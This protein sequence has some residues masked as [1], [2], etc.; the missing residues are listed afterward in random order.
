MHKKFVILTLLLSLTALFIFCACKDNGDVSN[1]ADSQSTDKQAEPAELSDM[2]AAELENGAIYKIKI[3]NEDTFENGVFTVENFATEDNSIV[4]LSFY[5]K[6]LSQMW[7]AHKNDDGTY[8]LQN[9]ASNMY[10][11]IRNPEK[12]S[13]EKKLSV[14]LDGTDDQA[15]SWKIYSIDGT[16]DKC[17]MENVFSAYIAGAIETKA[18]GTD[19]VQQEKYMG[20]DSQLWSFEKIHDGNIELPYVLCLKGDWQGSSSCPEILYHDGIYYNYNMTGPITLKTSTDLITWT[21]HEDKY[22]LP[23]R[24]S[25]MT[26]VSGGDRIWAP[27]AY[28]IGD[29]YFLYYCTSSAGSQNSGIGVAVSEDPSKN[30][31]QD[32]GLVIRSYKGGQYNCIDPNIF[33][34][35]D[36]TVF[37]VFGSYWEGIFMRKINP[38]TG[39]LDESD[40][41]LYHIAK[42][43][44]D[45]E[46]PYLIKQGE[47]YYLF[48][49]RGSLSKGTYYWAVGR[50]K[51]VYGP[52][53]D[54]RGVDMLSGN[55]GTRLTEWKEGIV[56]VAHAQLF[57]DKNGQSYMVSESWPYRHE[58]ES[59]GIQLHISTVVWTDDGW[60]VT[61][62]DKDV[63]YA[64]K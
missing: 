62:L 64:L 28:K 7:K 18:T 14:C 49:A 11:S 27:G 6:H 52:Y 46:A 53:V 41:K 43:N 63:L 20:E 31:W 37:L 25:W 47:Y 57:V 42:G 39:K 1:T 17:V 29:K 34:D 15:K 10:L 4:K 22:A 5:A 40:Q 19:Y 60:P 59:G 24:P 45:M 9:M 50:S 23:S 21:L 61:A 8:R 58:D 2:S 48:V 36:G 38:E 56:G 32:M 51:S 44:F 12:I 16:T 54:K 55:G 35:D 13:K 26:E 30:D 3:L 33:I